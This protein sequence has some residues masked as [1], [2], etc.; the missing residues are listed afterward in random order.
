MAN[1]MLNSEFYSNIKE[2]LETARKKAYAAI[3]FAMVEAYWEI[4]KRIVEMQDGNKNAEYGKKLIKEISKKLTI[5]YGKGFDET[6]LRKMR[7]FYLCFKKRDALRLELSWTHY[8]L[9]MK[10]ENENAR[11]FYMEEAIKSNWST[12]QLARQINTFSYERLLASK[13]NY[14]VVADTTKKETTMKPKD[15][16]K[17]PYVLEFLGINDT[18]NFYESDLEQ[19]LINRLQKFLL[20]LGRGFSFIAR[21]QHLNIEGRHFYIDLVFYHYI[22]KCFVLLD[23]KTGD[24]T[25]QDIGQMQMYVNYYTKEK[26][27]AGDNPPIGIILCSD[28]SDALV[29]YTIPEGYNQIFTSKYMLYIP[30]EEELRKEILLEREY[31]ENK[32]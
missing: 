21:Q 3:N 22:L 8:R 2:I 27:L 24:L 26:M 14:D 29:K 4:G 9:I 20:E 23:L 19:G 1:E 15:V 28:K 7:Q 5:D 11:L 30:T 10:V 12:R 6:N 32:N 17:D 16:I 13:G 25:H 31:L 18:S